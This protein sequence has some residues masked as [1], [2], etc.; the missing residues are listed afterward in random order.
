LKKPNYKSIELLRRKR[1]RKKLKRLDV[2]YKGSFIIKGPSEEL[3]NLRLKSCF[4]KTYHHLNNNNF[5]D[6]SLISDTLNVPETFSFKEKFNETFIFIKSFF[7]SVYKKDKIT[8]YFEK[9]KKIDISTILLVRLIQRDYY[10]YIEK[11]NIRFKDSLPFCKIIFQKSNY[12][13]VNRMLFALGIIPEFEGD[14][15]NNLLSLSTIGFLVGSKRKKHY[16]ESLK[17]PYCTKIRNYIN[18]CMKGVG[19]ELTEE[20]HSHFDGLISEILNNS[21]DH[22]LIDDWFVTGASFHEKGNSQNEITGEINLVIMN[23]GYSIYEGFEQTKDENYKVYNL[24]QS[25]YEKISNK[26]K[27]LFFKS[28]DKENIYFICVTRRDKQN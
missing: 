25:Q 16:H 3:I 26:F 18:F 13:I 6:S 28:Y 23:L 14:G 24:M 15:N 20:G 8:I 11:Y 10:T 1:E 7:S 2:F 5:F 27:S 19:F 4:T 21:E 22:S 12:I 17:G 9:C